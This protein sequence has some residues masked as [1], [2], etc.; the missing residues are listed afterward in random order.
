MN[1]MVVVVG[2]GLFGTW[3]WAWVEWRGRESGGSGSI[4]VG[5][6][7]DGWMSGMGCMEIN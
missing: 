4:G 7:R 3:G 6:W 5:E 1:R 2:A